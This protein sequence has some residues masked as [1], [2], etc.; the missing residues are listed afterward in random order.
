MHNVCFYVWYFACNQGEGRQIKASTIVEI[1]TQ[2]NDEPVVPSLTDSNKV[3]VI[4]GRFVLYLMLMF[5][6]HYIG[7]TIYFTAKY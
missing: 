2:P 4:A 5:V 1:Y 3:N 6:W 7:P